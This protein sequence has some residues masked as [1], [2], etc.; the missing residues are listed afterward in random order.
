MGKAECLPYALALEPQAPA[1][2]ERRQLRAPVSST[3][4]DKTASVSERKDSTGE[5]G[6]LCPLTK[7]KIANYHKCDNSLKNSNDRSY[8][9]LS[10][11]EDVVA[12]CQIMPRERIHA[13]EARGGI[14]PAQNT[15]QGEKQ[16]EEPTYL[17]LIND[18]G[19]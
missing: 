10:Q 17:K 1:V 19:M 18:H 6:Y 13:N 7:N 12:P 2:A 9:S 8:R 14:G 5:D 4:V 3:E 16:I 11:I 15:G